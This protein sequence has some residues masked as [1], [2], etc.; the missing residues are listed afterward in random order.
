MSATPISITA[1]NAL[2]SGDFTTL[3]SSVYESSRWVAESVVSQRPFP[4]V[5]ALKAAMA[6]VIASAGPEKQ[7]ALI[8][9]HP[10]L[11][12]RGANACPNLTADSKRE[13]ASS[14][15]SALDAGEQ[16]QFSRYNKMYKERHGFPFIIAVLTLDR[17]AIVRSA[18]ERVFNSTEVEFKRALAEIEKIASL[19]IN[20]I[21]TDDGKPFTGTV[22]TPLGATRS[23]AGTKLIDV[24]YGKSRVRVLKVLKATSRHDIIE[25][26]VQVLLRG[27]LDPSFTRGDNALVVPTD[28]CKNT[29][30]VL[31]RENLTDSLEEF[32]S[33]I[34]SHF[35][36]QYSHLTS[37]DVRMT[38]RPWVRMN[39]ATETAPGVFNGPSVP[40]DHS[41]QHRGPE[42][43]FTHVLST[44]TGVWIES[45]ITEYMVLKST[46]SGFSNF[47]RCALTLLPE[48]DDRILATKISATWSFDKTPKEGF[49]AAN[50]A[51]LKTLVDRFATRYSVSVQAT[52]YEMTLDALAAVPSISAIKITLPNVHFLLYNMSPFN[53]TNENRVFVP[54]DE[55]HGT[56]ELQ[57]TRDNKVVTTDSKHASVKALTEL[58]FPTANPCAPLPPR[59]RL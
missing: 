59:P 38:E 25:V 35:L 27:V 52:V 15:M 33:A 24:Q 20:R 14:G 44:R 6:K 5:A 40:H 34:G 8:K 19:R 54:T 16:A 37:V 10:E 18:G 51:I 7:M 2:P 53:L 4:T 50:A 57:T 43:P 32:G 22:V 17:E 56:I 1:L 13:Q 45:G 42:K 9:S 58:V 39:A 3:L 11:A 41:F 21:V 46:G 31:A 28:T 47:P 23:S 36:N 55:P 30:L 12:L 29:V 49:R 26:D 48:T